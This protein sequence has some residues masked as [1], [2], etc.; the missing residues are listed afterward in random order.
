[1]KITVSPS[2][3]TLLP[4]PLPTIQQLVYVDFTFSVAGVTLGGNPQ[5]SIISG[6]VPGL[7]LKP[8]GEYSGTPLVAGDFDITVQVTDDNGAVLTF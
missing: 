2:P 8:T 3:A 1:M 4:N 6:S 5:W 7:T